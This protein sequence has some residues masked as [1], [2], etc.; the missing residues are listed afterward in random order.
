M[1]R[2]DSRKIVTY[3]KWLAI[4]GIFVILWNVIGEIQTLLIVIFRLYWLWTNEVDK[5]KNKLERLEEQ[6]DETCRFL[7]YIKDKIDIN[8]EIKSY[9][10]KQF[11]NYE[12]KEDIEN[13]LKGSTYHGERLVIGDKLRVEALDMLIKSGE[14]KN[15]Q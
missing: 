12:D 3:L 15:N 13:L 5:N 1:F 6:Y 9:A 10:N 8:T 7:N 2:I 4:V 14:I 11:Y